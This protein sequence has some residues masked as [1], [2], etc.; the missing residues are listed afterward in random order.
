MKKLLLV[1]YLLSV[2]AFYGYS[3]SLTLSN[4]QGPVAANSTI[5][6]TGT[7]DSLELLTYMYVKNTGAS[8]LN[9]YCKKVHISDMDSTEV[10]MCWAGG[11]YPSFVNVSPNGQAITPGQT[12]TDFVAH[13][14]SATGRGF[15]SG[16]SVVRWVFYDG[17]NPNDS[18]S[19]I[20]KY[21]TY[22][23]GLEDRTSR[24]GMLSAAY[25]NPADAAASFTYAV[26][27]GSQGTIVIRNL[28]GTTVQ[29]EQVSGAGKMSIS[30]LGLADGIYFCSLVLDGK[31]SLTRKLV[32]RH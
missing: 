7:S 9:V 11:C 4:L 30:T 23:S 5:V 12:I 8:T 32:V 22:P 2:A 20:V 28:V 16:E 29:S 17:A 25:P 24:Q 6:Q 18:V 10:T 27:A 14:A 19:V 31:S 21:T 13:Y 3:Q 15:K 1:V 26:P